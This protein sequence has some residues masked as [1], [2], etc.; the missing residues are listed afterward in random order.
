MWL[1]V[2]IL[3]VFVLTGIAGSD[4]NCIDC[5]DSSEF[6]RAERAADRQELQV[7]AVEMERAEVTDVLRLQIKAAI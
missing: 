7:A 3:D 4:V 5:S 2:P 6:C 1:F